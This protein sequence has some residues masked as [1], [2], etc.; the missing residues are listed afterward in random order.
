MSKYKQPNIEPITNEIY[1]LVDNFTFTWNTNNIVN[2]ITVPSGFRYDG[3]TVPRILWTLSGIR[4]DG[5]HRAASLIHDY[6]YHYEGDLP[7][8]VLQWKF[9]G[10]LDSEYQ[11]VTGKWSRK[12]ADKLFRYMLIRYGQE[13]SELMYYF[14]RLFGYYF[15]REF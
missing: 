9:V 4:P 6:I 11:D 2:R 5:I 8:G 12:D 7:T 13:K 14:S 1:Q 3:A 10:E 15:W